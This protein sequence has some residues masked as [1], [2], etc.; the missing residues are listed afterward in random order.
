MCGLTPP[1]HPRLPTGGHSRCVRKSDSPS[2]GCAQL[3]RHFAREHCLYLVRFSYP[4][5]PVVVAAFFHV[6]K[7]NSDP[8]PGRI[9]GLFIV[10]D[11]GE[12]L[13]YTHK[14][15]TV[16]WTRR[17]AHI[18]LF[19]SCGLNPTPSPRAI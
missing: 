8:P 15:P 2:L 7:S 19:A 4:A 16:I 11:F 14:F 9:L 3:S 17:L 6:P 13:L 18:M 1:Q 5:L 10:F 12:Y